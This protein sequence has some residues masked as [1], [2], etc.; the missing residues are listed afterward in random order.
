MLKMAAILDGTI[1]YQKVI[2]IVE[3]FIE[4]DLS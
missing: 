1:F 4:I 3:L 2:K